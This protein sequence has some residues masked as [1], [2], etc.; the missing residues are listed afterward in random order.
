M[1]LNAKNAGNGGNFGERIIQKNLE[2]GNYPARVV[3]I[4]DFGLQPQKPFKGQDKAPVQEIGLTYELVDEFM[5]DEEG[6]DVLDKPRWISENMPLHNLKADRAKS[7]LRYNALDPQ[8]V[9]DGDFSQLADTPCMVTVVNNAVG[10]KVYDNIASIAAMRAR[11]AAN[12]PPL[13]SAARVFDL[14]NPDKE[15]FEKFPKWMQEKLCANLNYK[16]SALE[17]MIGG[18]APRP[19]AKVAK[20]EAPKKNRQA[21]VEEQNANNEDFE[22]DNNPY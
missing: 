14:D 15:M 20:E 5:K 9:Y 2:P 3:Q 6:E 22:A 4:I 18:Q 11:D 21:P 7:T 16:G 8:G 10:D 17:A 19:V 13:K 1:A 12:T